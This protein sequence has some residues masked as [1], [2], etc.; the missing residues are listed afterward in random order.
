M[1]YFYQCE[2]SFV[3]GG[4]LKWRER[5]SNMAYAVFTVVNV[6]MGMDE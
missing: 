5:I 4:G 1:R 2:S 3:Y 6:P